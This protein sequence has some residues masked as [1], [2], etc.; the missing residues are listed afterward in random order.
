MPRSSKDDI[1]ILNRK[2]W[3]YILTLAIVLVIFVFFFV[4]NR[5]EPYIVKDEIILGTYV[6]VVVGS[7]KNPNAI[8]DSM[9]REMKR[10]EKKFSSTIADS[11]ISKINQNG[12]NITE[13]DQETRFVIERSLAIADITNGAFDPAMGRIIK[14][15]GF[16]RISEPDFTPFVPSDGQ[17]L[18]AL[19]HC[20]YK[21]IE[22]SKEGIYLKNDVQ[23]DLGAIAKGYAIDRAVQVA[24]EMD[25]S[26]TG[27][28]DAGGDIGIIGPKFGGAKWVVAVKN[29]RG[30]S[31]TDFVRYVQIDQGAIVTSGDYERYFEAGG[32]RYHHIFDPATGK[33]AEGTISST[34]IAQTAMDADALSTAAFVLGP[35]YSVQIMPSLGGQGFFMDT[36]EKEY[37]TDGWSYFDIDE[38]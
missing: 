1:M 21:N 18:Q 13:I 19:S 23:L 33:P 5:P 29:P 31:S 9:I 10:I 15:W 16:D 4:F 28:V 36:A 38:K 8:M 2:T 27:Y 35:R 3:I 11:I 7:D 6:R 37:L 34:I 22:I 17:I 14:L 12:K 30:E 25:S 26:C 24:K 20:G 32:R